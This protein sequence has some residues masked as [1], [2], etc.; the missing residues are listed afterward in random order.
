MSHEGFILYLS[1]RRL[2]VVIKYSILLF[3]MI[4]FVI[5]YVWQNIEMMRMKIDRHKT[6]QLEKQIIKRN[7]RLRY[8][9]EQYKRLDYIIDYAERNRMRM[10][11]PE[12]FE[13]IVIK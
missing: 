5:L 12:D 3:T 11:T 8:E 7:D 10:I 13:T 4:I 6:I 9:I 1:L 2:E